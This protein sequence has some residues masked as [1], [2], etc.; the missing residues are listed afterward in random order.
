MSTTELA[1]LLNKLC[2]DNV[3]SKDKKLIRTFLQTV[4]KTKSE[5]YK[6]RKAAENDTDEIDTDEIDT[7]EIDTDENADEEIEEAD[8]V[9]SEPVLLKFN[10]EFETH[11]HESL[12]YPHWFNKIIGIVAPKQKGKTTFISNFINQN[13]HYFESI[14]IISYNMIPNI[15][16]LPTNQFLFPKNYDWQNL[17]IRCNDNR[18]VR[19]YDVL[20]RIEHR[21]NPSLVVIDGSECLDNVHITLSTNLSHLKNKYSNITFLISST[22]YNTMFEKV[23]SRIEDLELFAK[24]QMT[25]RLKQR[26]WNELDCTIISDKDTLWYMC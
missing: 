7:D 20:D 18:L 23:V 13:Q 16:H 25:I 21:G 19:L 26:Q 22:Q 2:D 10:K 8:K 15:E 4:L 14:N 9:E 5:K 11:E 6:T 12:L 1:S 3:S 24:N 17:P